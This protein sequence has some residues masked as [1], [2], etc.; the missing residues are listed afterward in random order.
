MEWDDPGYDPLLDRGQDGVINIFDIVC[1]FG[2]YG[3]QYF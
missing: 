3:T 1:G 2:A